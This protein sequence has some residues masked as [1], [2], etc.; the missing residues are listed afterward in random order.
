MPPGAK[1]L[2]VVLTWDEPPASVGAGRAVTYDINLYVDRYVDCMD[3]TGAC[4]EYV[5]LSTVDNVE[6]VVVH[7]PA[8]G[9]YRLKVVPHDARR[10][11]P[12]LTL[13]QTQRRRP[14]R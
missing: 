5:S 10:P 4:G 14:P 8:P 3:P 6:Y 7:D 9:V 12:F 2:V 13:R 11:T 1:R